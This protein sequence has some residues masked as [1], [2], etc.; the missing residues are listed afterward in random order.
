M[1]GRSLSRALQPSPPWHMWGTS[2]RI[3]APA[4]P[5]GT[6][7]FESVNTGQLARINYKRPETWSFFFAG[8][9]LENAVS[10]GGDQLVEIIFDLNLGVGRSV[11]QT[12]QTRPQNPLFAGN[13][14]FCRLL[15]NIPPA[16]TGVGRE[17]KYTTQVASPL[18]NDNLTTALNV[19]DWFPAQ[20]INCQ[21]QLIHTKSD[22][23]QT[24]LVEATAYFAPRT[25][26]RPDWWRDLRDEGAIFRGGEVDGS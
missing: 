22:P 15:W 14:G 20:D 5:A 13:H 8:R 17:A 19:I 4:V 1:P 12:K 3:F 26:L 18:L 2:E 24:V 25:H 21:C 23:D 9:I 10:L 6:P 11:F 7:N 16:G